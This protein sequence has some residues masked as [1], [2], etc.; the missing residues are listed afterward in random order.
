[1]IG[2]CSFWHEFRGKT[3]KL[4]ANGEMRCMNW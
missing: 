3:D 4:M 2:H 1:M